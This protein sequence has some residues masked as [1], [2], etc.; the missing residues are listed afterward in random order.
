MKITRTKECI[1]VDQERYTLDTLQKYEYLLRGLKNENYNTPMER[2]LKLRKFE[3]DSMTPKQENYVSQFPYQ[4]IVGALT[5]LSVYQ[6][7][8]RHLISSGSIGKIQQAPIFRACKA[9]LQVLIYLRGTAQ[10]SKFVWLF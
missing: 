10:R 8:A 6:Y 7:Q 4:N 5:S 2:D 9:L 3:A 1:T